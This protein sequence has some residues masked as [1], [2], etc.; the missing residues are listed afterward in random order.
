M[1]DKARQTMKDRVFA[2]L[3][4]GREHLADIFN[5]LCPEMG[6][7]TGDEVNTI[8]LD[9][10]LSAEHFDAGFLVR[11]SYMILV[12]TQSRFSMNYAT[13]ILIS[14]PV[15]LNNYLRAHGQS[16]HSR[17]LLH[18]PTPCFF[19]IYT[20]QEDVPSSF[21]LSELFENSSGRTSRSGVLESQGCVELQVNVVRSSGTDGILNQYVRFCQIAD[22]MHDKYGDSD[23]AD[24]ETV[25]TCMEEGILTDVLTSLDGG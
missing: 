13:R 22:E 1:G 18:F 4:N 8:D 11:D 2:V 14:L 7:A 16:M 20:G 25:K 17:K 19:I 12:E 9:K 24:K 15:L 21:L 5:T 3:F 23:E 10:Y 6:P